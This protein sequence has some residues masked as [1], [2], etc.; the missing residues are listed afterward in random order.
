[1]IHLPKVFGFVVT[2]ALVAASAS[3]A[4]WESA[5][6]DARPM[7][8]PPS[9][10]VRLAV[11]GSA[12]FPAPLSVGGGL[13]FGRAVHIGFEY[14]TLPVTSLGG[15]DVGYQ[16]YAGDLRIF[17]FASGPF[18]FG[19]RVGRQ[20]VS[21]AF[22]Q[23]LG[24]YGTANGAVSADGWYANPRLGFVWTSSWGLSAGID[25]GLRV[26][27][28]HTTAED[29]P[30][31]IAAPSTATNTAHLFVGRVIPSVTLLQLGLMF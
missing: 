18:Y 9:E 19:A 4:A 25:A 17:P 8:K 10:A 20:H 16:S 6:A 13:T 3:G 31:G 28:S 14:G 7:S 27:L 22:T 23:P 5:P 12:G 2:A 21:A 24:A 1:M 26:P 30:S 11:Y 29:V 15:V